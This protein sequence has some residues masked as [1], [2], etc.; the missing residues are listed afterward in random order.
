MKQT[1]EGLEA[2][3]AAAIIRRELS[4]RYIVLSEPH[5][6]VLLT[7]LELA[8][9]LEG[10]TSVSETWGEDPYR[11]PEVE[12]AE[13]D[14]RVDFFSWAQILL[15]AATGKRPPLPANAQLLKQTSLP[16]KVQT[17]AERCLSASYTWRPKSA[18]EIR[19]AIADWN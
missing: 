18:A 1:L 2:M 12:A 3:H 11:A 19:K 10:T 13:I 9:L 4:P 6:D 17:I 7:E 15:H 5:G 14:H 16:A 8:K